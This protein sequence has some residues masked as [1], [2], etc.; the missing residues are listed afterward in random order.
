MLKIN[1]Q[2]T[3]LP[4]SYLFSEI[5]RRVSQYKAGHPEADIISLGIGDV[6]QPLA[7][8]VIAALHQAVDDQ[9]SAATFHGYGPEQGYA[10]L[11]ERIVNEQYQ[12]RNVNITADE[13]FIGDGA[14]S[15][16]GNIGDIFSSDAIVAVCD[17]VYPV[18]ID[19]NAM[20]GRAGDYQADGRWNRLV[21][22][23]CTAETG[24]CP[25]LPGPQEPT[26]DL[27]YLCFPNNPTGSTITAAALKQ[28]VDYARQ[29]RSVI[30]YDAAYEA[31]IT[32]DLP[33][34]IFEIEGARECAIEFC[35]F[36]KL[37]GFTGIRLGYTI[38]PKDLK[39]GGVSLN[40]LWNRRQTTKFNG[41]SYLTQRAGE[42]VFSEQGQREIRT[43]IA[44]YQENARTIR[45]GLQDLGLTV[46]GGVNAPY[47]WLEAPGDLSSWALFDRML[48]R[49]H[50]V[51][52]PGSGFGP[53]GEGYF[54]LTAFGTHE[55]TKQAM[56]RLR[57]IF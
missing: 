14:K 11:R 52:T 39:V 44:Y 27:I 9:A 24:F 12:K 3:K 25:S 26:P 51:G 42:A 7:P 32:E 53:C 49:A 4:G 23:P 34:S 46:Y 17:P 20:A 18:Y 22:L 50:V 55:K 13:I 21:Y 10:F 54:R 47:I 36:S 45:E 41:A 35:S 40:S 43:T 2:F 29:N 16:T 33:H 57:G 8:S 19:T 6:T 48:T 56:E 28:W 38:I 1:E 5:A 15:D 30:L 37:A 31:Y